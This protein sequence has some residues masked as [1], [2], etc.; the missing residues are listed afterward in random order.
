[1]SR[2]IFTP[3]DPRAATVTVIDQANAII[4]EYDAQGF[5]LTLR[6][7]FYQF[8]ARALLDNKF[9]EYKRLGTI[10]RNARDGGLIDWNS[11]EDRTREVNT[12][13]FWNSP[14]GIISTPQ[15]N[16]EKTSGIG[17]FTAP[18]YG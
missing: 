2:E 16:T 5:T 6:Q 15:N 18:K 12:H 10:I 3:Y 14:A 4:T 9:N 17:S 8:V 1:M 13:I 11:I 7:L